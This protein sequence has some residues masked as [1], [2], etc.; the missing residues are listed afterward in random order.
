MKRLK[1]K[2]I[3]LV[4]TDK[5]AVALAQ[6]ARGFKMK[7]IFLDLQQVSNRFEGR[8]DCLSGLCSWPLS[9]RNK[10]NLLAALMCATILLRVS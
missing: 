10:R 9:R 1:G 2:V 4:G 7:V 6:R 8:F 3:G 5:S